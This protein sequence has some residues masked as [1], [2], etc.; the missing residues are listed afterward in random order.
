MGGI[1][2]AQDAQRASAFPAW[3]R[4]ELTQREWRQA[5]F[6]R[7]TGVD[8]SMISRWLHGRRPDPASLERVAEALGLDL[9]GLLAMAGYRQQPRHDDPRIATLV[10]KVR[11]VEWTPERF[12]IVDALLEDLR[13]RSRRVPVEQA[14]LPGLGEV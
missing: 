6:S 10:A 14:A 2:D 5:D 8:V 9:D 4:Q 1:A 7:A 13:Q 3:L 11:Q 12:L